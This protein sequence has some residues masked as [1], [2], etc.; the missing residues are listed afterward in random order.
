MK[1]FLLL[2]ESKRYNLLKKIDK[3]LAYLETSS[4]LT[5]IDLK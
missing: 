3:Y 4:S 5:L 2:G 1:K